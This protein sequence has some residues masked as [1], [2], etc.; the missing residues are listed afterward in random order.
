MEII[1]ARQDDFLA[2]A[3]LDRVAWAQNRNSEFIPDGEHVWRLWVEHGAVYCALEDESVV[4]AIV[5]FPCR[6]GSY[7]VHKA[8]VEQAYR[9]Q[10]VGTG[11]FVALLAEIDRPGVEAFLTVDPINEAGIR[12]YEKWGFTK[13]RFVPGYYR[14]HEDRFVLTRPARPRSED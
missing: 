3:R 14:S 11:L 9:S 12:L 13:R 10:R 1:P 4:G 2:I 6:S 7:C 8:F 5:A